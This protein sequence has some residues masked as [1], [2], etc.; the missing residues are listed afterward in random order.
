M[1]AR[2]SVRILAV[3]NQQQRW[4][5]GIIEDAHSIED[6]LLTFLEKE[7]V[8]NASVIRKYVFKLAS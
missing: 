7:N 3:V 6:A 2:Y 8:D 5:M 1:S 4:L